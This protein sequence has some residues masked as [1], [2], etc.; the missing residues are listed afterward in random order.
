MVPHIHRANLEIEANWLCDIGVIAKT[1][2]FASSW[3]AP[4]FVTPNKDGKIRFVTDHRKLNK[5]V[6]C[7]PWPM[8]H[9]ADMIKNVGKCRCATCLDLSVGFYHVKLSDRLSKLTQFVLPSGCYG[10]LRMPVELNI[11]PDVFQ[12]LMGSLLGDLKCVQVHTDVTAIISNGSCHNHLKTSSV[13]L[14]HLQ[15]K[16]MA[17]NATKSFW[18]TNKE[19]ECLGFI[20]T[21]NGV[22]P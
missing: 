10:H 14:Q 2:G 3:C 4:S 1:D 5:C 15:D 17:V 12:M 19:V 11:S 6:E 7:H 20:L 16:G 18:C 8:P 13:M 22:R 21:P 9:I